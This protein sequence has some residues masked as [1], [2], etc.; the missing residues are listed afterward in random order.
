[1]EKS[2]GDMKT[3]GPLNM[4]ESDNGESGLHPAETVQHDAVFGEVTKEGPNYRSVSLRPLF[5]RR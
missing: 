5:S 3:S 4:V 2:L 1:M